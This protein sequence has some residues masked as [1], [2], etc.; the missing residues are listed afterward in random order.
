MLKVALIGAGNHCRANHARSLRRYAQEHPLTVELAAVCDLDGA[1]AERARE[2]FGFRQ[3]F[4]DIETMLDAVEPDAVVA[5]LPI[6]AILPV[7]RQLFPRRIP[8]VVEK[9]LGSSLDEAQTIVAAADETGCPVM[10][11]MN[12]RFDPAVRL[13]TDW[14]ADR[15]PIRA[16]RGVQLRH[17]RAEDAFLWGTAIHLLDLVLHLA[18][19]LR[20]RPD[21]VAAPRFAAGENRVATLDGDDGLVATLAILPCCGRVEERVRI[22]GDDYCID[23]WPGA[24]QPWRLEAYAE[25]KLALARQAPDGEPEFLRSGACAETA[26]CL[27]ALLRGEPLPSPSPRDVLPASELAAALGRVP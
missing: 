25:R 19:P 3:A 5:I 12:R 2:E 14:L 24:V 1:K 26:A 6:P 18:G 27:D 23:L 4:T 21:S 22:A 13:A 15:G 11:S 10:V 16:V 17:R 9:P 7:A 20:L 8:C